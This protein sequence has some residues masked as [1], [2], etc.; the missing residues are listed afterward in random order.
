MNRKCAARFSL[1]TR[2]QLSGATFLMTELPDEPL[3]MLRRARLDRGEALGD[4]LQLYRNYLTVL[5]RIQVGRRLQRKVDAHDLVQETFLK[6]YDRFHQFH[7]ET[8][9]EFIAWLRQ[10]LAST[11][12]DCVRR[13]LGAKQ[14][15]ARLERELIQDLEHS[16]AAM[17]QAVADSDSTPSKKAARREEAV[18]FANALES[19]P[20]RYREIIILRNFQDL[21]FPEI[22]RQLDSSLDSVKNIWLRALN[23][24]QRDLKRYR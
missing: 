21:S 23:R 6:A 2:L 1:G 15:N 10:I 22:A 3:A 18:L 11:A 24:L 4:L 17:Q 8:E 9:S 20:K 5:A 13:F 14:R 12:R 19:L 7:G 16:S